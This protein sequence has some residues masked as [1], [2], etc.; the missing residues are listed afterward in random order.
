M[1]KDQ[2]ALAWELVRT[3]H[4]IQN[5]WIDL[6]VNAYRFPNGQVYEP[7]Y[8]YSRRDY[9]V[10]VATDTDGRYIC[11]RQFRQGIGKV[12]TEFPAGGLERPGH[13]AYGSSDGPSTEAEAFEAAKRE[14][15]EETGYET[16][17]WVHL[18]TMP[19]NATISDNYAFLYQARN[20]R[21]V[22]GQA[23]DETEF[24]NVLKIEPEV[25]EQMIRSGGVQ[26]SDHVLAWYMAR[27]LD[28]KQS[29]SPQ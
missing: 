4:I 23:L 8:C 24:L 11:V 3:E 13:M 19:A 25:F 20:C 15:R 26:Q 5:E 21:R 18:A 17:E 2:D 28:N 9:V 29:G 1:A 6:R 27:E 16:D 7:F 14:L 12:T 10:I 22:S